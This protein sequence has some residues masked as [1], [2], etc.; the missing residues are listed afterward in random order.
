VTRRI[1]LGGLWAVGLLA[2]VCHY[3]PVLKLG[4]VQVVGAT[5]GQGEELASLLDTK[6]GSNLLDVDLEGWARRI[7]ARPAVASVRTRV[8]LTGRAVA[9]VTNESPV[10][11]VDTEP[12]SGTTRTG[13]LLPLCHHPPGEV[14]PLLTGIGGEPNYYVPC[15]SSRL[16]TALAFLDSWREHA[17]S[18]MPDL[19]EIHV[20]RDLEVDVYLWPDRLY[21]RLGRGMWKETIQKLWPV[22]SRLAA[23]ERTLDLR[24]R[25]QVLEAI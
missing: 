17:D 4:E 25:G 11:L 10:A 8:T 21:V 9:Y 5:G 15:A 12:A 7:A 3:V 24:F 13:L 18:R 19:M 22:L 23:S 1:L 14:V 16:G 6:T 2:T 20:T